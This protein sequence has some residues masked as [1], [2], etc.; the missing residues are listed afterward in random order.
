MMLAILNVRNFDK[1]TRLVPEK[2]RLVHAMLI[3][4]EK[5]PAA[6][7]VLDQRRAEG[8]RHTLATFRKSF[9]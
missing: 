3:N 6:S 9:K 4:E 8:D 2:G 7:F 5:R 1:R